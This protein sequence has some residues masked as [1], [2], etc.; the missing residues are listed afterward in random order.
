MQLSPK[1]LVS[2]PINP[3][4]IIPEVDPHRPVGHCLHEFSS[5]DFASLYFPLAQVLQSL[6]LS[7]LPFKVNLPLPH[8]LHSLVGFTVWSL[9]L[10]RGHSLHPLLNVVVPVVATNL[11]LPHSI[12]VA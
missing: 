9:Y 5:K 4:D 8:S 1:A 6:V 7:D 11:P 3:E 10:P 2:D 12:Q